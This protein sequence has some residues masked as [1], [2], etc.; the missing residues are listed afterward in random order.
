MPGSIIEFVY[1]SG[2][3]FAFLV[4]CVSPGW[5]H[6]LPVYL[7]PHLAPPRPGFWCLSLPCI[8][9]LFVQQSDFTCLLACCFLY[10]KMY[11]FEILI[12]LGIFD[13]K[14]DFGR[15]DFLVLQP[16][17]FP[18]LNKTCAL[19]PGLSVA[20]CSLASSQILQHYYEIYC[21]VNM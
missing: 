13:L 17:L 15:F 5:L 16:A 8:D 6:L 18:T 4:D 21:I 10:V 2:F 3:T 20:Q 7:S 19:T 12:L 1:F 14:S 11:Q 9:K